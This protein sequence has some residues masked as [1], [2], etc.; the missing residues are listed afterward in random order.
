METYET[1]KT[2][3]TISKIALHTHGTLKSEVKIIPIVVNITCTLNVKTLAE[4]AQLVS[5]KEEPPDVFTFKQL[6]TTTKNIVMSLHV[7]AHEWLLYTSK[8][9]RK[10]PHHKDKEGYSHLNCTNEN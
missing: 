7:H 6:P 2:A 5:Y 10:N 3:S 9:S 1:S 8:N 4:I